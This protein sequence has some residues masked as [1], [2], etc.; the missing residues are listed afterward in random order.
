MTIC[1]ILILLIQDDYQW[2]GSASFTL[3]FIKY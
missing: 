2:K 3:M 1:S